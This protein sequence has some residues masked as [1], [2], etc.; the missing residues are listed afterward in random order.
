MSQLSPKN[1]QVSAEL[2]LR[3]FGKSLPMSLLRAREAVMKKFIPHLK[4]YDLSPQQWR[5]IRFLEQEDGLE[6]S[7]LA[8]RC[9]LM[10]PSMSRISKNLEARGLIT[11]KTVASDQRRSELFLSDSGRKLYKIIAPKS[12]ERYEHITQQ[13]GEEKIELLYQL[14]DELVIALKE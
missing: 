14:L 1:K 6:M 10:V 13:F 12:A 8:E 4:K 5:V 2:P 7:E 11:R 9:F 3:E